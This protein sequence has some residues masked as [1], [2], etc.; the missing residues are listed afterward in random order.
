MDYSRHN[1][2]KRHQYKIDPNH[3]CSAGFKVSTMQLWVVEEWNSM[4]QIT[5]FL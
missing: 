2:G 1:F 5:I 4:K 3:A